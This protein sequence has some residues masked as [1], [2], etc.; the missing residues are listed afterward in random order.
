[1]PDLSDATLARELR[2][3][4]P[5]LVTPTPP[6]VRAAVRARLSTG[7]PRRSTRRWLA[8][9]AAVLVALTIAVVPPTRTAVAYAATAFLRFAGIEFDSRPGTESPP[10]TPSPLPGIHSAALDEAR[11]LA[12]FPIAVPAMLGAPESVQ[13]A[14]PDSTGAPRVV[15][16]LYHGGTVRLDEFDGQLE[17]YFFKSVI[18][19]GAIWTTVNGHQA[20]WIPS[21]HPVGYIDRDG[22]RHHET[23]RLAAATLIWNDTTVTYRLEGPLTL[24][25]ALAIARSIG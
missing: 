9:A 24:D 21:P 18:T 20:V 13:L 5:W 12:R 11:R 16:L 6:D 23:A 3:L 1:V 8:A 7:T 19:G 17:P 15:S 2:D 14:D 4:G 22:V 10:A 25:E